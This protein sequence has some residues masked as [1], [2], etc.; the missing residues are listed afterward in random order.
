MDDKEEPRY[1]DSEVNH[2]LELT[3]I[4]ALAV[5]STVAALVHGEVLF[6]VFFGAITGFAGTQLIRR[7]VNL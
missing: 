5:V 1:N 4:T 2:F 6:G 7:S 3:M